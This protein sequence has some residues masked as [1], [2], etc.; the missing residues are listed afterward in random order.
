MVIIRFSGVENE[1]RGVA[2]LLGRFSGKTWA[3]GDWLI[4]LVAL[5]H[6]AGEGIEFEGKGRP[7]YMG[8]HAPIRDSAPAPVRRCRRRLCTG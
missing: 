4:P 7:D 2:A 5:P 1:R 3:I 8:K 6:L